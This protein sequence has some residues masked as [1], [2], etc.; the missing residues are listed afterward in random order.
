[1]CPL[2]HT[3]TLTHPHSHSHSTLTHQRLS[4][5][6]YD[7]IIRLPIPISSGVM[8]MIGVLPVYPSPPVS[9]ARWWLVDGIGGWVVWLISCLDEVKVNICMAIIELVGGWLV[10][11]RCSS[12]LYA[13]S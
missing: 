10:V 12:C 7:N 2:S 1:M 8:M 3:Q 5:K 4:P 9:F 6:F 13:Y 11:S